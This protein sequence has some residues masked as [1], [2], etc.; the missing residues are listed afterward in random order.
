MKTGQK[1]N[2]FVCSVYCAKIIT[3]IKIVLSKEKVKRFLLIFLTTALSL[4]I[5]VSNK[6]I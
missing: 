4:Q 1:K 2:K 3:A 6:Y 5:N